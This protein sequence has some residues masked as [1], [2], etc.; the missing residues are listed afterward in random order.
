MRGGRMNSINDWNAE[1][2]DSNLRFISNL[3]KDVLTLLQPQ[4]GEKIVDLGC[5]T[6]DLTHG[7]SIT[8]ADVLGIDASSEM[9]E[10]A[11][12]KYPHIRFQIDNG[13]TFRLPE[14]VD[15]VFSNAALHW[16]KPAATVV[17]SISLALK[18][19]GRFVAEFGGKGNVQLVIESIVTV[20]EEVYGI[21]V[22]SR[23]PWYFPSV[24]EYASL[25]EKYGF[26]VIFAQHFERPTPL[27]DG[28]NGINH[29]LDSFGD[30]FFRDL[31]YDDK[32]IV[33]E[34]MKARL[35]D[36]LFKADTWV[37]DYKRLRIV[38]IKN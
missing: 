20:M 38:A 34:K 28:E 24:G 18:Q 32:L 33:Y 4:K 37:A 2:Y 15:A 7:I 11:R 5:G 29:W 6:G 1:A 8:G 12:F 35:R 14:K 3:G 30:D 27:T 16:M 13:Q 23:N 10:R 36:R 25:V 31:A 26:T 22:S 17:E 9:I 19:G 21:N